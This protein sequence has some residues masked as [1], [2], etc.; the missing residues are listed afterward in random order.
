M[1]LLSH[2]GGQRLRVGREMLP[3]ARGGE[4]PARG[5]DR[6]DE[7]CGGQVERGYQASVTRGLAVR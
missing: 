1:Q 2:G 4:D 6:G 7:T 3:Q 5:R